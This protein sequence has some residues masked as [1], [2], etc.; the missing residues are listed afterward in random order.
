MSIYS[1]DIPEQ[2]RQAILSVLNQ[3]ALPEEFI[4]VVDGPVSDA[5]MQIIRSFESLEIIKILELPRN[6][7]LARARNYAVKETN[8]DLVAVM[9]ADDVSLLDRFSL[10]LKKFASDNVDVVGG[11]IAEFDFK[12]GRQ[13]FHSIRHVPLEH[14]QI[15]Q[16]GRVT[17]P[18]NHVTLMFKKA[19]F[20]DIGGYQNI[21]ILEDYDF[22][23]R[24]YIHGATFANLEQVLVNVRA[25]EAQYSRR[26]GLNYFLADIRLHKRMLHTGYLSLPIFMRNIIIR[27]IVRFLPAQ[28]FGWITKKA[29]RS[30]YLNQKS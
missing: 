11:Q 27:G 18:L 2:I 1:G 3:T 5:L 24:L 10:Q 6:V 25:P 29:L 22:F 4:I 17:S 16:R 14:N 20:E 13:K 28:I 12:G 15:I 30:P 7:G 23:H 9:D 21:R 19:I 26:L 8:H